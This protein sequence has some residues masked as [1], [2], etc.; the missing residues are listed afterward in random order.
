MLV[1]FDDGF[2]IKQRFQACQYAPTERIVVPGLVLDD[3]SSQAGESA[4]AGR[5]VDGGAN[6]PPPAQASKETV[7]DGSSSGRYLAASEQ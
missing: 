7:H 3:S 1:I 6:V 2:A 5:Y 4:P